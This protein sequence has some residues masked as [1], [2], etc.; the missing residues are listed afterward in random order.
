MPQRDFRIDLA[1]DVEAPALREALS[2]TV[3][4]L[5]I[6]AWRELAADHDRSGEYLAALTSADALRYPFLGD[7][8]V[9]AVVNTSKQAEWLEHGRAGFHLAASWG[10]GSGQWKVNKE[11]GLYARVPF[12]IRTPGVAG[13]M[14]AAV[15]AKARRLV[16][17]QRLKGFGDLYKQSKTYVFFQSYPAFNFPRDLIDVAGYTWKASQ[18]EGLF[19]SGPHHTPK[20][21]TQGQYTTVRTI[22]PDSPGWY[23]P[24]TRAFNFADRAL[25]QAAPKIQDILDRA[26]AQDLAVA[27]GAALTGKATV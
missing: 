20:G 10:V 15:Y 13:G 23:I 26:A 3:P 1:P 5:I 19:L 16:L 8:D 24:P 25:D 9:V 2:T 27:M 21:G 11:G 4:Q 6:A 22:T 12:R 14:P 18:Y 17:K 7:H